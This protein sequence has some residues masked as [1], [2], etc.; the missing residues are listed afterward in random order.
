MSVE[1][2]SNPFYVVNPTDYREPKV[3]ETGFGSIRPKTVIE[4]FQETKDKYPHETALAFK[5]HSKDVSLRGF[6]NFC[7]QPQPLL[8]FLCLE[9]LREN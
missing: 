5:V 3:D 8:I 1:T 2:K 6:I 9:G 7:P 4:V